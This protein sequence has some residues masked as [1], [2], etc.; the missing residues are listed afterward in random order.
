MLAHLSKSAKVLMALK[1]LGKKNEHIIH[2]SPNCNSIKKH[3][4][5]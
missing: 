2:Q 5:L 1:C 4:Y 3:D